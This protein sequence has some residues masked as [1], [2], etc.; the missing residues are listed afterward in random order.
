MSTVVIEGGTIVTAA[1]QALADVAIADGQ[2]VA[3]GGTSRVRPMPSWTR[4]ESW[5]CRAA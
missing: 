5:C 2:I 3:I 4:P 1:G